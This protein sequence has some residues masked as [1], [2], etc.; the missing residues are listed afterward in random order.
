MNEF[1][2][3]GIIE[4]HIYLSRGMRVMLDTDLASLYEVPTKKLNQQVRRN[5]HRFP[6]DFM[7]QLTWEET[8]RLR[9]QIVT[10]E[11][12][13][14]GRYPK[15]A[16]LAFTEQGVAMLS[17]ILNSRKA[18]LVNIEIMR[19][20]V[21]LRVLL[22]GHKDLAKR[23]ESLERK[24]DVHDHQI[25]DVFTAIRRLMNLEDPKPRKRIGFV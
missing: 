15:Y 6:P 1:A 14:R 11:G 7:V 8:R 3:P 5:I 22:A 18:V 4:K 2:S 24:Y 21:R 16:P 12:T 19:A 20:F 25:Q 17:G 9:S 10:L 13:G 23:L